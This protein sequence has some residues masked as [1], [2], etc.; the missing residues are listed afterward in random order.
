MLRAPQTKCYLPSLYCSGGRNVRG[1]YV[2]TVTN[3]TYMPTCYF[4]IWVNWPYNT[5]LA[6]ADFSAPVCFV[7]YL[8]QCRPARC[9]LWRGWW[10]QADP[11]GNLWEHR[12]EK[13]HHTGLGPLRPDLRRQK[14]EKVL[15]IMYM[16]Q[17]CFFNLWTEH[18]W[19]TKQAYWDDQKALRKSLC[20]ISLL[21]TFLIGKSMSQD[22]NHSEITITFTLRC[23]NKHQNHHDTFKACLCP[24]VSVG[25]LGLLLCMDTM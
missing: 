16:I 2:K 8:E 19:V 7:V 6:R 9:R 25:C 4:M 20:E 1:E 15:E 24:Q 14:I 11:A 13:S 21:L 12:S 10:G 3:K 5:C 18:G 17:G 23:C 22:A